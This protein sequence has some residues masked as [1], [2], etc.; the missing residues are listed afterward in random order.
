[1]K[2]ILIIGTKDG[3]KSTTITEVCKML[4]PTKVYKLNTNQKIIENA[5]VNDIYNNTFIIE[6]NG[7]FILVV[8]GA[9]PEQGKPLK[10]LIEI[11]LEINIKISFLLVSKRTS[12]RKEGFNTIKDLNDFSELIYTER[13]NPIPLVDE[14]DPNSF[15]QDV[16][17]KNRITKIHELILSNI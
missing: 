15:K 14:K 17:W 5:Q 13:I 1:M 12:E 9:P 16:N 2:S 8:A 10:D 3:G 11:C 7:K 4:N 6:V